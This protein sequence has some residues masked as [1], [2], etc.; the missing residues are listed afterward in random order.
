MVLL[1]EY[2]NTLRAFQMAHDEMK[3]EDRD[4]ADVIRQM[5]AADYGGLSVHSVVSIYL[6]VILYL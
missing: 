3:S 2:A 6:F 5:I 4:K 1:D